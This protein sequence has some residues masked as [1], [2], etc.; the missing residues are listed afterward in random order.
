MPR[1]T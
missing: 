1:P